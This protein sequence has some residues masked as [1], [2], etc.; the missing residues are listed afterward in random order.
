MH[1]LW[2]FQ[3]RHLRGF[4]GHEMIAFHEQVQVPIDLSLDHWILAIDHCQ[5]HAYIIARYLFPTL[6]P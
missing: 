2:A 4:G 6:E 5:A 3:L 1:G